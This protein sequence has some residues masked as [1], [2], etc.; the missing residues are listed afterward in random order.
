M[1]DPI[2]LE[3]KG[4]TIEVWTTAKGEPQWRIKAFEQDHDEQI[5]DIDEKIT[6]AIGILKDRFGIDAKQKL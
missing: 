1:T 4:L 3:G 6:A 2:V 5:K